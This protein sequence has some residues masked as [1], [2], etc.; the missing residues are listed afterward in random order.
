MCKITV[1]SEERFLGFMMLSVEMLVA[2]EKVMLLRQGLITT[3]YCR[4][5]RW[6]LDEQDRREIDRLCREY[7]D[8]LFDEA[9][10]TRGPA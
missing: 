4:A 7:S 1:A 3:D 2:V 8:W 9:P 10:A 5:P 6:N